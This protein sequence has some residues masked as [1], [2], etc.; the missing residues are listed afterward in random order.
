MALWQAVHKLRLGATVTA[1]TVM[2]VLGF[3]A[4][5]DVVYQSSLGCLEAQAALGY[6]S[7]LSAGQPEMLGVLT[8]TAASNT[9]GTS[10]LLRHGAEHGVWPLTEI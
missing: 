3:M 4:T 6:Y 5:A 9:A 8:T 7:P 2:Q 1:L 10:D